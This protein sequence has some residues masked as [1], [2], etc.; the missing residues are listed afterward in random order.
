[1]NCVQ[2]VVTLV[3]SHKLF[4][5][6][7]VRST[8]LWFVA[9]QGEECACISCELLYGFIDIA[10]F[11]VEQRPQQKCLWMWKPSC[12]LTARVC[13]CHGC[14]ERERIGR[15]WI[16]LVVDCLDLIHLKI[17][18]WSDDSLSVATPACA[19]LGSFMTSQCRRNG[20]WSFLV[21]RP[22]TWSHSC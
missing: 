21:L 10:A 13:L 5:V 3:I 1:M 17:C 22:S 19:T 15:Y 8:L 2:T 20:V 9:V 4:C 11:R 16:L 7:F 18:S 14:Q 6:C 12:R